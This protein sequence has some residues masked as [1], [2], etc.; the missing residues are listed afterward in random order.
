MKTKV[1]II[2]AGIAGITLAIYLRRANIDFVLLEGDKVGGKLNIINKIENYPGLLSISGEELINNLKHQLDY[3]KIETRYG[4]V[5]TILKNEGGFEVKTDVES[6]ISSVVVVATGTSA[7]KEE[8]VN[9]TKYRGLGV[10]YCATCDG[11]FFKGL[12]VAVY[13]NN[14]IA[15]EEALYLSNLASKV[16]FISKDNRLIGDELLVKELSEK[17]NVE[18]RLNETI[19]EIHGDLYGVNEILLS[20]NEVIPVMGVFPYSGYKS[21][22]AFLANLSPN[23]NKTFLTVNEEFMTSIP[24]LYAI[25]D[26]IDKKVRQLATSANDG[27]IA[28]STIQ[29][30]LRT[31]K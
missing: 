27:A 24:G 13:G 31:L 23:M 19:L 11:S 7:P 4:L 17:A 29:A 9:E 1:V 18:V 3:F 15:L 26:C 22:A 8:I 5:Q 2:G 6:I 14:N 20:N 28:S 16:Y 10:S 21:S 30:Y 25:G 12:D